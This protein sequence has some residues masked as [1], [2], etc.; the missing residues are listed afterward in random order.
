MTC[1]G[2]LVDWFACEEEKRC[3]REN[4]RGKRKGETNFKIKFLQ[5]YYF[6]IDFFDPLLSHH[7]SNLGVPHVHGL[8][9]TSSMQVYQVKTKT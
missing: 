4:A 2:A 7:N 8:V 3:G 6:A 1:G 9:S 5:N